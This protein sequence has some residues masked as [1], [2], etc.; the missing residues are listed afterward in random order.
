MDLKLVYINSVGETWESENIYEFLFTDDLDSVEGEDWDVYPANDNAQPPTKDSVRK[1]LR[2]ETELVFDLIQDS[3]TFAVYDAI[4]GVVA[5]GWENIEDYD[6][7]PEYRIYFKYGED[8]DSVGKKL[9][10]K[11]LLFKQ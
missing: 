4:D 3:E 10:K 1:V 2:L 9:L 7:Y 8:Y 6:S 5:I 11:G